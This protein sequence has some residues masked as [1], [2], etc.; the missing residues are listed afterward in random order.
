[1]TKH[2]TIMSATLLIRLKTSMTSIQGLPFV[3]TS[4]CRNCRRLGTRSCLI[5]SF[6]L[7]CWTTTQLAGVHFSTLPRIDP[8]T[9]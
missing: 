1:M 3:E 6:R 4:G 9:L 8:W 2:S 5:S 7:L